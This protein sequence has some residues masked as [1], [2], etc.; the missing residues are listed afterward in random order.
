MFRKVSQSLLLIAVLFLFAGVVPQSVYSWGNPELLIEIND[1]SFT[2]Q[3]YLDWWEIWKEPETPR[4]ENPDDFI[5]WMLQV[6]EAENMQLYDRPS[7]RKK[8]SVFLRARSLM[9]LKQEEVDSNIPVP[10]RDDLWPQYE[11]KYVP[12]FNLRLVTVDSEETR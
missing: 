1:A 6:Q 7:Y 10:T 3:D 4:P 12:R 9:L 8:V 5:D 11:E 2:K